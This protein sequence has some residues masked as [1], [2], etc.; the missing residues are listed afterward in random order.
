MSFERAADPEGVRKRWELYQLPKDM[1]FGLTFLDVA[2]WGGQFCVEARLRGADLA[3]GVDVVWRE[4]WDDM[5]LKDPMI[6]FSCLDVFS[7][8]FLNIPIHDVV[9]CAGLLYHVVDPIGLLYR[10]KNKTSKL[11]VLETAYMQG[12]VK[13]PALFYCPHNSF[14][15]DWSNWLVPNEAFLDAIAEEL[16]FRVEKKFGV[17][18]NRICLHLIPEFRLS[19]KNSPRNPKY[20]KS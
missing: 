13:N 11:L 7:P 6:G 15:G 9:L 2:C 1:D 5:R 8:P 4:K 14:G 12:G 20:M 16:G 18:G 10:L 17:G 3:Y 19:K